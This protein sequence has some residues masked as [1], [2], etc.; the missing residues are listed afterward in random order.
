MEM[1]RTDIQPEFQ[2]D[3]M[4]VG[5]LSA[6]EALISMSEHWKTRN[7]KPKQPRPLTPSSEC[8]EDDSVP[9][10]SSALHD[11]SFCMTPPYSPPQCE[12]VPPRSAPTP[13]DSPEDAAVSKKYQCAS[14]IR[15][16]ADIQ[17]RS[18]D[19]HQL[20]REDRASE[21]HTQDSKTHV[22]TSVGWNNRDSDK[23]SANEAAPCVEASQIQPSRFRPDDG[24]NPAV[25]PVSHVPASNQIVPVP[26]TS[27]N[28]PLNHVTTSLPVPLAI[29]TTHVPQQE[30]GLPLL[31]AGSLLVKGQVVNGP[32]VLLVSQPAVPAVYVQQAQTTP[33][34]TRFAAIA[35]APG[36]AAVQQGS[37]PPQR[38]VSR[39]RSHV[40]PHEDCGKTYFKSSH[41]K[42]HMRTHTGEKPFKCKWEGCER[43]FARSDELSRHRRTHTGEKR[44]TCPMCLSRFMRSDHL[45]KHARRH[46]VA[47]KKPYWALGITTTAGDLTAPAT[48]RLSSTN[49]L[50]RC[51]NC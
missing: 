26:S 40:C 15:H 50:G 41:L 35:P 25:V 16:T 23:S 37:P 36:R 49:S 34:G 47:R 22:H 27:I 21:V 43:R 20:L 48:V 46:F 4:G 44:F 6:V 33:G 30:R 7:F 28:R 8:S 11:S 13:H 45:A 19:T 2:P 32:I 1:D 39:A 51:S 31:Q 17:R 10:G 5:D 14:V 9:S 29:R 18:C 12:P 42:A 3:L 24:S 38:E